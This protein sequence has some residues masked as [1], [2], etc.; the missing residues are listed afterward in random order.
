MNTECRRLLC[1]G[2]DRTTKTLLRF[3]KMLG[4]EWAA[5][6]LFVCSD[7]W[8]PYLKVI[9]RTASQAIH[10]LDQCHIVAKLIAGN[11]GQ[12]LVSDRL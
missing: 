6:L 7:M 8:P 9:A 4:R 10:I 2:Q 3:F 1:V 5:A 11:R 12:V